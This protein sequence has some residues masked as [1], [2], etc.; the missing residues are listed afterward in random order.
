MMD[1]QVAQKWAL[2]VG[3]LMVLI[4]A[5]GATYGLFAIGGLQVALRTREV[6]VPSLAGL[7]PEEAQL[8]LSDAGLAARVEPL[9]RVH[10]TIEAGRVA[11]QDPSPGLTTRRRRSVKLWLSSGHTPGSVPSLIG[12]SERAARRRLEENAFVLASFS[13][14]QSSRYPTDAVVAQEP[15]PAGNG[16]RV[17]LL[18]NRGE[19]G[20]TYV[21][22]DLIGVSGTTAADTLRAR[23]F[24]VT[25]VGEHPYPGLSPGIVL[26]QSPPAGFQIAPGE[27]ISLEVSR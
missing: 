13:E 15:P 25:V 12:A 8:V 16:Q 27:A 23:G 19:R 5:L 11:E 20:R 24:R 1:K 10:R 26:R 4:V 9:R 3:K 21:M 7:T 22:P 17:S 14:I 6:A 18:V 2:R